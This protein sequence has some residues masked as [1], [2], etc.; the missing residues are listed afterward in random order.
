MQSTHLQIRTAPH[1]TD[2]GRWR[3]RLVSAFLALLCCG[4]GQSAAHD[5]A[6]VGASAIPALEPALDRSAALRDSQ[7]VLGHTIGDYTLRDRE[8]RPV[9]LSSYRGKPLLVS[10]IYTGCFQV[11][12]T[13]T[14][15]LQKAVAVASEAL[16]ADR[17]NVISI[18]FNQPA[19][20]PQAL[21]SFAAQYGIN[22]PNW[23]FLSPRAAAVPVLA[24]DFG[25][26]FVA[27]PAG[28][29]HLLQISVVDADGRIYQQIYGEGYS[30]DYLTE[31]LR[32]L[33]S[34]A[35]VTQARSLSAVL[36]QVRLL[37]S[38]YDP[39]TGKYRVSYGLVLEFAGFATFLIW[40][41]WFFFSEWLARRRLT[42]QTGA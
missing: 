15:T 27:T 37:C 22:A 32:Q 39:R 17:F 2:R 26:S 10:F 9:R 31:P 7:A 33:L 1:A 6:A 41:V 24:H 28:F 19:D 20:S 21:K 34:G 38:V 8:G 14:K 29:D 30:A 3:R 11:C 23:K 18:G 35:P 36:D 25:F 13:T 5:D 40:I 42:R 16:G 4:A 12:P